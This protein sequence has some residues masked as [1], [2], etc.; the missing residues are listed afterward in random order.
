MP[1]FMRLPENSNMRKTLFFA[2]LLINSLVYLFFSTGVF[3]IF[4]SIITCGLTHP[5]Q[6]VQRSYVPSHVSVGERSKI[7]M[8]VTQTLSLKTKEENVKDTFG[9]GHLC[10]PMHSTSVSIHLDERSFCNLDVPT[11]SLLRSITVEEEMPTEVW[12]T[13]DLKDLYH[14]FKRMNKILVNQNTDSI[15]NMPFIFSK[16][17]KMSARLLKYV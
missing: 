13:I 11:N 8:R 2:G 6:Q 7:S 16:V 12:E 17:M 1:N 5:H 10:V 3:G 14:N 9:K 15:E 4:I